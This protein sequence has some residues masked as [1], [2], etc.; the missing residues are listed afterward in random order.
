MSRHK[1]RLTC[2]SRRRTEHG[3]AIQWD[4]S[5]VWDQMEGNG[6]LSS[7]FA[8][9]HTVC[10]GPLITGCPRWAR[11]CEVVPRHGDCDVQN[12]AGSLAWKKISAFHPRFQL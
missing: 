10:V 8:V 11:L 3:Q 7:T 1:P 9:P 2:I 6:S 5:W 4:I 12:T